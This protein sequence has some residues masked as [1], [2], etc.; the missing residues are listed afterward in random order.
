MKGWGPIH[1]V[2]VRVEEQILRNYSKQIENTL[3]N[4]LLDWAEGN[5]GKY[6]SYV[7]LIVC[8]VSHPLGWQ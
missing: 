6:E 7:V 1:G 2:V 8:I 3:V 5:D 4:H